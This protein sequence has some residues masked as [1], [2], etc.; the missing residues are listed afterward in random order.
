[1]HDDISRFCYFFYAIVKLQDLS[2]SEA[3]QKKHEQNIDG[4]YLS[5]YL[6]VEFI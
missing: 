6:P 4:I 2:S 3:M 5:T 1:M